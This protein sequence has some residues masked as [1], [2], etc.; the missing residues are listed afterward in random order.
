MHH[1]YDLGV[2]FWFD[3]HRFDGHSET[4][5]VPLR[6]G[7]GSERMHGYWVF[8][9][10][11]PPGDVANSHGTISEQIYLGVISDIG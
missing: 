10:V 4:S 7:G 9:R 1:L 11:K 8:N 6:G 3:L 2:H 5:P